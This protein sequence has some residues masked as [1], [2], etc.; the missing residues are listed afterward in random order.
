MIFLLR[1]SCL[2]TWCSFLEYF[3]EHWGLHVISASSDWIVLFFVFFYQFQDKRISSYILL[4]I[5]SAVDLVTSRFFFLCCYQFM[6]CFKEWV[7][8]LTSWHVHGQVCAHI[9]D[10]HTDWWLDWLLSVWAEMLDWLLPLDLCMTGRAVCTSA[11]MLWL[12]LLQQNLYLRTFLYHVKPLFHLSCFP[13]LFTPPS[14][15]HPADK[16]PSAGPHGEGWLAGSSDL[17]RDWD[18]QRGELVSKPLL[19][20]LWKRPLWSRLEYVNKCQLDCFDV[21]F[22]NSWCPE[23]KCWFCWSSGAIIMRLTLVVLSAISYQL[24]DGLTLKSG[25][26]IHVPFRKILSPLIS[27]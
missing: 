26:I 22:R 7:L 19:F 20:I 27:P 13:T 10:T 1:K 9:P 21:L 4:L 25:N 8:I 18:D 23:D 12:V 11:T 16:G 2:S 15:L 17:Q 3:M 24:L 14:S 6:F 5:L